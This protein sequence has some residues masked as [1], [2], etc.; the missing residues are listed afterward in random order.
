MVPG[1]TVPILNVGLTRHACA[2]EPMSKRR[3]EHSDI[4]LMPH[5]CDMQIRLPG[6]AGGRARVPETGQPRGC[7]MTR[8]LR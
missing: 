1:T 3:E 7:S 4:E 6:R 2:D 5:L 8:G